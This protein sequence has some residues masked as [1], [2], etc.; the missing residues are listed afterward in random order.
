MFLNRGK[1]S[2]GKKKNR[3]SLFNIRPNNL[4]ESAGPF[5][6]DKPFVLVKMLNIF[7]QI[8]WEFHLVQ[9]Q[10]FMQGKDETASLCAFA[11]EVCSL[12]LT[13]TNKCDL[14]S[15]QFHRLIFVQKCSSL[16]LKNVQ[17][18]LNHPRR[19][20]PQGVRKGEK[21]FDINKNVGEFRTELWE[22]SK[23]GENH[24]N[25]SYQVE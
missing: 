16:S 6:V 10:V 7:W 8:E 12:K 9:R 13:G 15:P 1:H 3:E 14:R 20:K 18:V 11:G 24:W 2:G 4:K 17:T 5:L 22:T 23:E 19:R 21:F 25:S